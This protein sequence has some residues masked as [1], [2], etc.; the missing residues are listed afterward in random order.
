MV[1]EIL[2][3]FDTVKN[4]YFAPIES[5]GEGITIVELK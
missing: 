2:N 5:G 4:Y 3:N 1:K